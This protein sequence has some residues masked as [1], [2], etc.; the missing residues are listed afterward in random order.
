[1]EGIQA[2]PHVEDTKLK[3]LIQKLAFHP[4]GDWLVGAGG[5]NGGF[6]NFYDPKEGK[7]LRQEK[8][9]MHVHSFAL[10]ERSDTLYT[11]GHG[12]IAVWEFKAEEPAPEPAK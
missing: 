12:K 3:G 11:V 5:D 6:I 9:P 1:M 4:G 10:N 7:I 8:A 2:D